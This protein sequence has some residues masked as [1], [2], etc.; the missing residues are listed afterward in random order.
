MH[1]SNVIRFYLSFRDN[2]SVSL[3]CSPGTRTLEA[4]V[5]GMALAKEKVKARPLF[6]HYHTNSAQQMMA[7]SKANHL[8]TLAIFD[9]G[10]IS[11]AVA[12][13]PIAAADIVVVYR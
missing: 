12:T 6:A 2:L 9:V 5:V 10:F 3:L 4:V 1:I 11:A 8:H 7:K 13:V